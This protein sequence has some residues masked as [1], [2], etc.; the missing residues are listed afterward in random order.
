MF[1]FSD[2]WNPF[3]GLRLNKIDPEPITVL[4]IP[5]DI[6]LKLNVV[7]FL[8][9]ICLFVCLFEFI[10]SPTAE[11]IWRRATAWSLI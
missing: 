7:C 4:V 2:P 10:V 6:M 9:F 8:L 1:L 5:W 3:F 11:G